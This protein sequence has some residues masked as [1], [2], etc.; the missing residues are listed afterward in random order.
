MLKHSSLLRLQLHAVKVTTWSP[1][2]YARLQKEAARAWIIGISESIY[3]LP[4]S[5][6]LTLNVTRQASPSCPASTSEESSSRASKQPNRALVLHHP[7]RRKSTDALSSLL[8]KRESHPISN[9]F[10]LQIILRLFVLR[11]SCLSLTAK[12][13]PTTISSL[14]TCS[15]GSSLP[16]LSATPASA[17]APSASSGQSQLLITLT[18]VFV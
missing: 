12:S 13:M 16:P 5:P 7:L 1:S 17:R 4:R 3:V 6:P 18:Y 10:Y 9:L 11:S 8:T 2:G 15:T 14:K